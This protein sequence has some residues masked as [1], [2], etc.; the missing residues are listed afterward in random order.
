MRILTDHSFS[1]YLDYNAAHTQSAAAAAAWC[2][3]DIDWPGA[4]MR[5]DHTGSGV[6]ITV[7]NDVNITAVCIAELTQCSIAYVNISLRSST[8]SQ[9]VCA[10][11]SRIRFLRFFLKIQKRD[12]LRFLKRHFKKT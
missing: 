6:D 4:L 2:H 3:I 11:S 12:F 8:L 9:C 5:E 7:I 10:Y 1:P